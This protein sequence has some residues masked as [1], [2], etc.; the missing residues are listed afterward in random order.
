[1]TNV[2]KPA[3]PILL[4]LEQEDQVPGKPELLLLKETKQTLIRFAAWVIPLSCK[5]L[6]PSCQQIHRSYIKIVRAQP[7]ESCSDHFALWG[8]FSFHSINHAEP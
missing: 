7:F 1:M 5:L 6:C 8:F 4:S 3:S 2:H